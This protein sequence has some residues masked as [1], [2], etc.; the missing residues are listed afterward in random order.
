VTDHSQPVPASAGLQFHF[1]Y[2]SITPGPISI[3][4]GRCSA[5]T[6]VLSPGHLVFTQQFVSVAPTTCGPSLEVTQ[7]NFAFG[8]ILTGSV[9]W[10]IAGGKLSITQPG[11][12]SLTFQNGSRNDLIGSLFASRGPC[13]IGNQSMSGD[14]TITNVDNADTVTLPVEGDG[15][16]ATD[17]PSGHYTVTGQ[18][19]GYGGQCK[20]YSGPVAVTP[21]TPAFVAVTCEEQ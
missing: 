2:E 20:D 11:V 3:L 1:Q 16:F 18:G 21:G 9:T 7:S 13:C 8:S 15:T 17:L 5:A 12:G 4:A 6:A 14:V 10:A 19:P